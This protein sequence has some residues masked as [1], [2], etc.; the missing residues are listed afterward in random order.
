MNDDA[1]QK[2]APELPTLKLKPK[3]NKTGAKTGVKS[4]AKPRS[5]PMAKHG[6]KPDTAKTKAHTKP[7]QEKPDTQ[8]MLKSRQICFELLCAVEE[9]SQL[10]HALKAQEDISTLDDRDRRFVRLLATTCLRRRGQIEKIIAPMISRRPFGAQAHANLILLMGAVQLLI[11]K[12]GAH[13][14]VDSTV[15]LMRQAGFERLCGMAN[16]VMRRLTR[17]GDARFET[18][19]PIDNLPDWLLQS[20]NEH[21]GHDTTSKLADMAMNPPPL[22]ISAKANPEALA[23]KLEGELID[24][25]TIRRA[26]DGDPSR[27][28]GFADGEWW[29][30]DAAAAL[31]ARL[32]GDIA[33]KDVIDLCA[34]PGG[35]TAQLI[36]AGANVTAID[37]G[38]KRVD[39]LRRNLGRLGMKATLK[40]ADGRQF[41]PDLPVDA[42]L[43]DAPCSATGTLRRRPDILGRRQPEDIESLQNLQWELTTTALGWLKAGGRLV[44]ATCSLQP[45]EGEEMIAA[46]IEAGEDK[47]VI[48]PITPAQAGI[49]ARSLTEAGTLRILP[50]QYDDIGGVDGFF[51][52]RLIAL[53]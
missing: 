16:A 41:V 34:A 7:K 43:L 46:I 27:L 1:P 49:F 12:T 50:H 45:E 13:A 3:T 39:R 21:W 8:S 47:I 6:A 40:Q 10:D 33:G 25:Y 19:A 11:L 4:G 2:A 29:V 24:N 42:I 44:Y 52:A 26:F 48:D 36:A 15:E 9:G 20:W 22:D 31:P 53:V 30:Q 38:R 17:E 14:A 5:K 23:S 32:L 51:A 18:T 35:K 28:A 37:S